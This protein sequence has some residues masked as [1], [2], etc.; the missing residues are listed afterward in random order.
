MYG[1]KRRDTLERRKGEEDPKQMLETRARTKNKKQF[2]LS[3]QKGVKEEDAGK[4]ERKETRVP[5]EEERYFS[6]EIR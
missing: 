3:E 2:R 6:K 4:K 5:E 1:R